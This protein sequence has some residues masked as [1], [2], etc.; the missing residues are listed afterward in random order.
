M[1]KAAESPAN[2]QEGQ[3]RE[4][5]A[6]PTLRDIPCTYPNC[7]CPEPKLHMRAPAIA[8]RMF[9]SEDKWKKV[10]T[11]KGLPIQRMGSTLYLRECAAVAFFEG[12]IGPVERKPDRVSKLPRPR[13]KPGGG[14]T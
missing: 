13:D 12:R 3:G 6:V 9:R 11:T 7:D 8:K 5:P 4:H 2:P 1:A 10:Y 14:R